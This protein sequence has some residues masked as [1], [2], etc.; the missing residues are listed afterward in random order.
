MNPIVEQ[1]IGKLIIDPMFR[2]AFKA[3]R[4]R[5]LARYE[6]TPTERDGLMHFD[7]QAIEAAVRN[8]QMSKAIP[9]ESWFW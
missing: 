7:V 8:L 6:L 9:T 2:Q 4:L 3:D 5:T 1:I